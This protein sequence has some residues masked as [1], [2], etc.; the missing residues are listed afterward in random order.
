VLSLKGRGLTN[1]EFLSKFIR[2]HPEIAE[3]EIEGAGSIP[4]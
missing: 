4:E 2:E 1:L 3:I